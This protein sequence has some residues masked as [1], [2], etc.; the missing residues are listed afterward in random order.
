MAIQV[1]LRLFKSGDAMEIKAGS[2]RVGS[3]DPKAA[4]RQAEQMGY[5]TFILE[6]M[7]PG[8]PRRRSPNAAFSRSGS[9]PRVENPAG[10][11]VN[12]LLRTFR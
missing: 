6:S 8:P 11:V 1:Q 3:F 12:V 9:E 7:A 4:R 5:T 2:R 10:A